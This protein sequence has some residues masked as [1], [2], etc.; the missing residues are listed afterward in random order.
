MIRLKRIYE[1]KAKQDG[2]RIL[3]ERLWPR[4]VRK[5][6][7]GIDRWL[8]DVAPSKELRQWFSH[9]PEK[10]KEFRKRYYAELREKGD[11]LS[12]LKSHVQEGNVTFIY[13]SRDEQHNSAVVLKD[14]LEGVS[15]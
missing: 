10:W 11:V 8:K 6:E 1:P 9:D 12:D 7:A 15:P 4:G 13:A 14:F 3:V 5:D 2:F